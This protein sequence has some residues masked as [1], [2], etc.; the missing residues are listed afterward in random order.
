M[1][2]LGDFISRPHTESQVFKA[3]V[4][5]SF[6]EYEKNHDALEH[7]VR[8][9]DTQF[10]LLSV[11]GVQSRTALSRRKSIEALMTSAIVLQT[12]YDF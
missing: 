5:D 10:A 7:F 6:K 3:K 12:K 9:Q 4:L 1:C 2:D 8:I 11:K